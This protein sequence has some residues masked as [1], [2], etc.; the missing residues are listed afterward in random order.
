MLPHVG[1]NVEGL[2]V[3]TTFRPTKG[4]LA[5]VTT[6][7]VANIRNLSQS[8]IRRRSREESSG[9]KGINIRKEMKRVDLL[10]ESRI[11]VRNATS[12]GVIRRSLHLCL[13]GLRL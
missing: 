6:R 4:A 10:R 7:L 9:K 13:K 12:Y 2:N 1:F 5:V 11:R 8:R 3:G